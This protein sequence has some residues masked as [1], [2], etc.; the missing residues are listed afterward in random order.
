MRGAGKQPLALA[1]VPSGLRSLLVLQE[2]THKNGSP[3]ARGGELVR[4]GRSLCTELGL[5]CGNAPFRT[6]PS[7][8]KALRLRSFCTQARTIRSF[9]LLLF[10]SL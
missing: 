6:D 8:T 7:V 3:T 2:K 9:Y 5:G 1:L 4:G 10:V